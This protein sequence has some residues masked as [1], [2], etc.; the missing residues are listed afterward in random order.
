M[1]FFLAMIGLLG[2]A[3]LATAQTA[4]RNNCPLY[5]RP[6]KL[7]FTTNNAPTIYNNNLNVTGIQNTIRQSGSVIAGLHQRALGLTSS[8][9][10]LSMTGQTYAAP[11]K[12]WFCIYLRSVDA[13]FSFN[14]MDV[15]V[16]SEFRP[17]SYEYKAVLDHENQHVAINRAAVRD[18]APRVRQAIEISL[19]TIPPRFSRDAQLGGDEKLSGLSDSAA[20]AMDEMERVMASRNAAIDTTYNYSAISELCKNWDQ[21]NVWP[22]VPAA[23][24]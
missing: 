20:S 18:Y 13:D 8:Q 15:L 22:T 1:W 14:R 17:A 12:G 10:G 11:I 23:K 3:G 6:V 24:R 21:G 7:N 9:V 5:T 2:C 16:A 4:A 19:Q